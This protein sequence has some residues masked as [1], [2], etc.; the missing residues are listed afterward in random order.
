MKN[1]YK[2]ILQG[3]ALFL[4]G[5][6]SLL[7][8]TISVGPKEKHRKIE[9]ALNS[10]RDG[11]TVLIQAGT[12]TES[13]TVSKKL[14]LIGKGSVHITAPKAIPN[15][16]AIIVSRADLTLENIELSGARVPD[17]N[18]AGIRQEKGNLTLIGCRVHNNENGILSGAV[19]DAELTVRKSEFYL[20]GHGDG[21]SH[22]IYAGKIKKLTVEDSY[23]HDTKV[24][25]HIKSRA[26]STE[27]TGSTLDDGSGDA[28]YNIDIPNGGNAVIRNNKVIQGEKN[29]NQTMLSY[30]AEGNLHSP[31]SILIEKN[32]FENHLKKGSIAVKNSTSVQAVLKDNVFKNIAKALDG[33]GT[34]TPSADTETKPEDRPKPPS[35]SGEIQIE[36]KGKFKSLQEALNESRDGDT[37]LIPAG[38]YTDGTYT[39]SKKLTLKGTGG[40]A[41]FT[42]PKLIPNKKAVFIVQSDT[43]ME[44]IEISGARVPDK[45][46]A[47]I[48][49]E[50]GNLT[51]IKCYIHDNE[52][53]VLSGVIPSGSAHI[54]DSEFSHNGLDG[55]SDSK[56]WGHGLYIGDIKSLKV[57][58]SRFHGTII[59]HHIKSRARS[60]EITGST[61]DDGNG[62]ASYNIDI[63]NGGTAVIR[64][65]MII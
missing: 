12:Y 61:L 16:K 27:I 54:K 8:D 53:G 43:V 31:S 21:Y 42:A 9:D 57:E 47:G 7:A 19:Q 38:T 44:N 33:P 41:H 50:K 15:Q 56:Y 1:N 10:A 5:S 6:V 3:S 37:I 25:H 4:I 62:D 49:Y 45:N 48:R 22:G 30:G 36:S 26:F 35:P 29:Q 20:N 55:Y 24:G 63:P 59:G 34:V 65:N 51:L 60:T 32:F 18:G 17:K 64:E 2:L 14:K 58:N 39:I 23:F 46:G 52:M 13:F 40:F 11:D 28:S